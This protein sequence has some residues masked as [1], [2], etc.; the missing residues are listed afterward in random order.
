MVEMGR[1]HRVIGLG[2]VVRH[3]VAGVHRAALVE[4]VLGDRHHL[5]G[6]GGLAPLAVGGGGRDNAEEREEQHRRRRHRAGGRNHSG[7]GVACTKKEG[8]HG[9]EVCWCGVSVCGCV[10]ARVCACVE[11]IEVQI[12]C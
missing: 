5:G 11:G 1:T 12:D 4:V 10:R 6:D 3:D 9:V 2:P 7:V 8:G